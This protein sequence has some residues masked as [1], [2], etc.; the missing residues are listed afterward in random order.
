MLLGGL[1]AWAVA[2]GAAGFA[3]L[4]LFGDDPWPAAAGA[5]ILALGAAAGL[6]VL[7]LCTVAG[8]RSARA[9]V[10]AGAAAAQA[11]RRLGHL[12]LGLGLVALGLALVLL[13]ARV[14][15]QDRA[16]R[17]LAARTAWFERLVAERHDL[18]SLAVAPAADGRAFLMDVGTRGARP[19]RHRLTWRVRAPAYGARLSEGAVEL[20]LDPGTN[21]RTLA[22]DAAELIERY[23]AAALDPAAVNVEVADTFV[24][25]VSLEPLLGAGERA[26]LPAHEA[27]NLARGQSALIATKAV[28][29]A[30]HFRIRGAEVRLL[31]PARP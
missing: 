28:E 18:A 5:V 25:E 11:R 31:D 21:R 2:G 26:R 20:S 15:E 23:R 1:A 14:H 27:H 10:R 12:L 8:V 24:L 4:Y 13:G 9:A 19:G 30:A 17:D 16:R 29:F 22:I 7:V 3:W 6:G